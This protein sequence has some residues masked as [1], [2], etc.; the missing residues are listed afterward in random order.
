MGLYHYLIQQEQVQ[1]AISGVSNFNQNIQ[2]TLQPIKM[3]LNKAVQTV[4]RAGKNIANAGKGLAQ[5]TMIKLAEPVRHV[6]Y[7]SAEMLR[8]CKEQGI[9]NVQEVMDLVKES[10][11]LVLDPRIP[12]CLVA[13]VFK[14]FKDKVPPIDLNHL[15]SG[16]I[17][18]GELKGFHHIGK[19]ILGAY[20]TT[21]APNSFGAFEAEY[22]FNSLI[23]KNSF[24]PIHWNEA[25]V[26]EKIIE[27]YKNIIHKGNYIIVGKTSEGMEIR[28]C[29]G[30]IP[31][32]GKIIV[33]SVFPIL[34]P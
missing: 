13:D 30:K 31:A 18:K 9:K 33:T 34:N 21:I 23:K 14:Q 12:P 11:A 20:K 7:D 3:M 22:T 32:N 19:N 6:L 16:Q 2:N 8:L 26:I 10:S 29:F 27:A 25:K 24:F 4:N 1:L 28:I 5:S 17:K 15:F